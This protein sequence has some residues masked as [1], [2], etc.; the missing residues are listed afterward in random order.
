M[1]GISCF[2]VKSRSACTCV[3]STV[4]ALWSSASCWLV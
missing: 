3:R 1:L 4:S 2:I